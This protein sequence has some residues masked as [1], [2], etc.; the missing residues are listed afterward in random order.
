MEQKKV[1]KKKAYRGSVSD[2]CSRSELRAMY[3]A[4]ELMPDEVAKSY[5]QQHKARI[6]QLDVPKNDYP[7]PDFERKTENAV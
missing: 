2:I 7:F 1:V 6:V 3:R 5:I 4:S